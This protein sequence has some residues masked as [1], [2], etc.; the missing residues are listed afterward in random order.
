[1]TKRTL[2]LVLF[3]IFILSSLSISLPTTKADQ[4]GEPY[5]LYDIKQTQSNYGREHLLFDI[6]PTADIMAAVMFDNGQDT[7]L[8]ITNLVSGQLIRQFDRGTEDYSRPT[9]SPDGEMLAYC[10]G[11]DP[12]GT[13]EIWNTTTWA[14]IH[15]I[16]DR[17]CDFMSPL[18]FSPNSQNLVQYASDGV[19]TMWGVNTWSPVASASG[20]VPYSL[21]F[22]PDGSYIALTDS[23][24]KITIRSGSDL[25]SITNF[26]LAD[27]NAVKF[28][29]NGDTLAVG[30]GTGGLALFDTSWE[31]PDDWALKYHVSD[32]ASLGVEGT[33]DLI[34][35]DNGSVIVSAHDDPGAVLFRNATNAQLLTYTLATD[36]SSNHGIYSLG[37]IQDGSVIIASGYYVGLIGKDTD[38]DSVVDVLDACP[39][40]SSD[41]I[42]SDGDGNCDGN[43]A[44]PNDPTEQV[45]TDGDGVGDNG[46]VFPNDSNETTDSD[47]DGVGDNGDVFPNDA[48]E[49]TDFDGDGIGDNSDPDDDGDGVLDEHDAFPFNPEEGSDFDGDGIGDNQDGD[50]DNDG[51]VDDQDE[52]PYD[53]NETTDTDGDGVGD[54]SDAFPND[55]T[56][57]VDPN[58]DDVE[59]NGETPTNNSTEPVDTDG[60]GY[61]DNATGGDAD[62]CPLVWGTST[63][64]G[65]F[66]CSDVDGD[67]W[68]DV[69]DYCTSIPGNSTIEPQKGCT[70]SDG[71]G[72]ANSIDAFPADHREWI[73]SDSDGVG[74][75]MDFCPNTPT[76]V[77]VDDD[78]CEVDESSYSDKVVFGAIGAGGGIIGSG[79][80]LFGLPRM[81]GRAHKAEEM[82]ER[83]MDDEFRTY[84]P[85]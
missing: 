37:V 50:D 51:I 48:N 62:D 10:W 68:A 65:R 6:S 52:F 27:R 25:S 76:E 80:L 78:G 46:D 63:E 69:D 23:A 61:A 75:G 56:K 17:A 83:Q 43:D 70:D 18:I 79:L 60:D 53:A 33:F 28:S 49:T 54:N 74:D 39:Y 38:L 3:L 42:D 7:Y 29:P 81:F 15:T 44:F 8:N 40:D 77:P 4:G 58:G 64:F 1:M 5:L 55:P 71:D 16:P 59:D 19:I 72:W 31:N 2:A 12:S 82:I 14:T 34:F 13:I 84:P 30:Q 20:G 47:G 67:G 85:K 45:D 66:G 36:M 32:D 9:F 26:S 22:S 21:D 41:N 24:S 57:Q 11:G 73:D 35:I